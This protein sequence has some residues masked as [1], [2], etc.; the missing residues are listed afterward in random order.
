MFGYTCRFL[1][2]NGN[3]P[4]KGYME[5]KNALLVLVDISLEAVYAFFASA[6]TFY[7]YSI[8]ANSCLFVFGE[9]R[10]E[11]KS[12]KKTGRNQRF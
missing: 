12:V 8:R 9:K 3:N 10:D 11:S 4:I 6:S 1:K 7:Y 2:R 5:R